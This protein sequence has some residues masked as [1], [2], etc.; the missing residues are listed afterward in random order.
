MAELNFSVGPVGAGIVLDKRAHDGVV[1]AVS[2]VEAA[3]RANYSVK[4]YE[5]P[6]IRVGHW[7]EAKGLEVVYGVPSIRGKSLNAAVFVCK[8]RYQRLLLCGSAAYL[9]DRSL[10]EL[11]A[12]SSMS[13]PSAIYTL[14]RSIDP[15]PTSDF[16]P[17]GPASWLED[18]YPI[19]NLYSALSQTGTHPV[20]FLG[21]VSRISVEE[22]GTR[23]LIG[24]P[25][26][27]SLDV[28]G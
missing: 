8:Q 9:L 26:F 23:N 3:L 6:G 27:V 7:F 21:R 1:A 17:P 5:D 16:S 2:E 18:G 12:G 28:P 4:W 11:D 22:D 10:P 13:D 14:L 24:T 15:E 25:L 20:S 19:L